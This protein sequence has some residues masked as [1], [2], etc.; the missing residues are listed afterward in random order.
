MYLFPPDDDAHPQRILDRLYE[1]HAELAD[2][3]LLK[4][5]VA[6][7]FRTV[8]KVKHGK[9]ALGTCYM[10]QVQGELRGLFEMLLEERLGFF[11]DYLITLDLGFWEASDERT[12]EVL[13]LHEAL[14]MG[15]AR[16]RYG[17]PRFD[18][19]GEPVWGI[20]GHDLEEFGAV[21]ARYGAWQPDIERF[22]EAAKRGGA[23]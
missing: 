10:P 5:K 7:I 3:A 6:V 1:T 18:A 8:E 21:V 15:Q 23:A 9:V 20:Q 4:P 17:T 14:H 19:M 12:R 13:V 11:P 2:V 16:D 22:I